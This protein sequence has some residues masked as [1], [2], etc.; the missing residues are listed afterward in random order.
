MLTVPFVPI[1][2]L[3]AYFTNTYLKS[4][5]IK[6]IHANSIK[7]VPKS[8]RCKIHDV[9]GCYPED[10]ANYIHPDEYL[11]HS[12][13]ILLQHLHTHA[14][15][16]RK[17]DTWVNI[18][19]PKIPHSTF[20]PTLRCVSCVCVYPVYPPN[21]IKHTCYEK[22]KS[23]MFIENCTK[24]VLFSCSIIREVCFLY[25]DWADQAAKV[26]KD[27]LL[28][29]LYLITIYIAGTEKREKMRRR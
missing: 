17:C 19:A 29:F 24:I 8:W 18:L 14:S 4:I 1:R 23:I 13:I 20:R 7:Y 11:I 26:S 28:P 9:L 5:F 6:S 22:L 2:P 27:K 21:N 12:F 10:S 25:V 16:Q 3:F 15:H